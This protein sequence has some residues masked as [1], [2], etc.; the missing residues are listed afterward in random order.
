MFNLTKVYAKKVHAVNAIRMLVTNKGL[1][2]LSTDDAAAYVLPAAEGFQ[3]ANGELN[4]H[5]GFEVAGEQGTSGELQ[6]RV[7]AGSVTSG[8][9]LDAVI[10]AMEEGG[11]KAD[12]PARSKLQASSKLEKAKKENLAPKAAKKEKAP[13]A[14]S[15]TQNG[16]R[17]PAKPGKTLDVW[18]AAEA[19]HADKVAAGEEVTTPTLKEVYAILL[20]VDPTFNKTTCSIQFYACRTFNGW[21]VTK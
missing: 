3:I 9:A 17:R 19:L 10:N 12:A 15:V 2:A 7:P 21:T 11:M 4:A 14:K 1:A 13:A 16:A 6:Q 20:A 5:Y 8:A 18:I